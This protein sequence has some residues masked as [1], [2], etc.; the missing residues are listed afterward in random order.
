[1]QSQNQVEV[2]QDFFAGEHVQEQYAKVAEVVNQNPFPKYVGCVSF[3]EGL[4]DLFLSDRE[5]KRVKDM[6]VFEPRS[7]TQYLVLIRCL[8]RSFSVKR[9]EHGQTVMAMDDLKVNTE[10]HSHYYRNQIMK[11]DDDMIFWYKNPATHMS[12]LKRNGVT[13][14]RLSNM[15]IAN[16]SF[17]GVKFDKNLRQSGKYEDFLTNEI[18]SVTEK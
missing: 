10:I 9:I 7:R 1:M 18:T 15:K 16:M 4:F 11:R 17:D 14:I 6:V 8:S 12:F 13:H 5:L 2:S 3:H